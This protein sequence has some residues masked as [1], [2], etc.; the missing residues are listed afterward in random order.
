MKKLSFLVI[1]LFS[2]LVLTCKEKKSEKFLLLTTPTWTTDTLLA[3]GVDAS[4]PDQLLGKFKGDAKFN[5]DGTGV[6]G[7]YTGKWAFSP[8]ESKVTITS[9]SLKIP[10]VCTLVELNTLSLKITTAVFDSLTFD[11]IYIRMTFKAK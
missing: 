4:G 11:P 9:A 2:C 1:I 5:G 6:F 10:I 8:D 3:N 7:T